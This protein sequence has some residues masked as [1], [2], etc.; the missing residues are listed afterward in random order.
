[1]ARQRSQEMRSIV[2]QKRQAFLSAQ[3][4]QRIP[5]LTMDETEGGARVAV[6][7]NY[8]KA[9]LPGFE[10]PPNRLIRIWVGRSHGGLLHG[11]PE[12]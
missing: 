8:L 4:G 10:I 1:V 2:A 11:C 9:T 7:T 3:V 5:A 12:V 6:T